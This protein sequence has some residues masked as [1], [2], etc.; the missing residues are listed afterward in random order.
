MGPSPSILFQAESREPTNH[1]MH[2]SLSSEERWSAVSENL[3]QGAGP[4]RSPQVPGRAH[5]ELGFA[6]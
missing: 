5:V 3:H 1:G 6:H 2:Q 4:L